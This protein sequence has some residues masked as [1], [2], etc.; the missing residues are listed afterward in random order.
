MEL[1]V[2]VGKMAALF[3]TVS[4]MATSTSSTGPVG[5][6]ASRS[7]TS[8]TN[9]P[10]WCTRCDT[11]KVL[12]DID[13]FGDG[14]PN[15]FTLPKEKTKLDIQG[16]FTGHSLGFFKNVP[17]V[18]ALKF[19]LSFIISSLQNGFF[20]GLT[21]VTELVISTYRV[22]SIERRAFGGLNSLITLEFWYLDITQLLGFTFAGLSRLTSLKVYD[23][24]E[25]K[26]IDKDAFR[27]LFSLVNL[28]LSGLRSLR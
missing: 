1:S 26:Q 11:D 20:R 9:C 8:M 15:M 21:N 12:C 16:N 25:L 4:A 13:K 28:E 19:T 3:V 22:Q 5:A 24:R 10:E 7:P 6:D 17:H 2:F 23:T 18:K 14:I 27:G